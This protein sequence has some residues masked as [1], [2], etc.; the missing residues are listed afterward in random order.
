MATDL[1][2]GVFDWIDVHEGQSTAQTYDDRIALA[3]RADAGDFTRFHVAEHHGATLGLAPSPALILAALARETSRIKLVPM[4]FVVPLYDPL[5]LVQE[6]AML[7]H[8]SR[9]RVELGIGKGSAPHEA[10]FFGFTPEDM[11]SRYEAFVPA[12]FEALETGVFNSPVSGERIDLVVTAGREFTQWYP[13]AKPPSIIKAAEHGQNT[14]FGFAFYSPPVPVI[15][16]H[17]DLFFETR[18]RVDHDGTHPRF[19]VL[20]HIFVA[21]T[22]EQAFEIADSAFTAHYANFVWLWEKLGMQQPPKPDLRELVANRLAFVGSPASVAE[23]A[24]SLIEDTGVNYLAGAFGWGD[25]AAD[26][27]LKSI[28]LFDREVIPAIRARLG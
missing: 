16:E 15:R 6:I 27:S 12:I 7:D 19:G 20:R 10:K 26:A 17:R 22:D 24:G 1:E 2:F 23:Q 8:L 14:I 28:D 11:A 21:D 5:R 25:L 13:S 4:T 18:A 3:R 9:G